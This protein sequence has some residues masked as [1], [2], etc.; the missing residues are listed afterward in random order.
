MDLPW[1]RSE[2]PEIRWPDNARMAVVLNS[3]YE[4]IRGVPFLKKD[5]RDFR[6][7][8]LREYEARCGIWRILGILEKFSV[9]GTIFVNGATA[10][11]FPESVL[12]IK[13][14][15]HEIAAHGYEAESLWELSREEES[16][17]VD[18]VISNITRI[19]DQPP[20]G[21]LSPKAQISEQTIPLLIERNFLWNSDFFDAELPYL[22][23]LGGRQIVEIP[24]SFST[25]DIA[26]PY[27]NPRALLEAW[28]D[29]F[30]YLYMES[31]KSPRMFMM[32]W[33]QYL[34]ARPSRAKA[35]EEILG[36]IKNHSNIWFATNTEVARWCL[37]SIQ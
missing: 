20:L 10:E 11:A 34:T 15:G 12:Q 1:K 19:T 7:M 14:S 30:D 22:I 18:K 29:E 27:T 25:D 9:R 26:L 24:R 17:L 31:A 5:V 8:S 4:A 2:F 35:L 3:E 33:H 6:E 32:T 13:N 36:H 21:W 23:E 28:R 16:A 37:Q